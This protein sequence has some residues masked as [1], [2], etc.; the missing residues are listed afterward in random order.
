[1]K[2]DYATIFAEVKQ[3]AEARVPHI[4]TQ[5]TSPY[6]CGVSWLTVNLPKH[7]FIKYLKANSI[8]RPGDN[9]QWVLS[10]RDF[11]ES[12]TQNA[13]VKQAICEVIRDAL[14]DR[15]IETTVRTRID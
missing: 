12:T 10:P 5:H 6:P 2:T 15:G 11:C 4:L 7:P 8:G 9:G 14:E 3:L 13:F 1:M